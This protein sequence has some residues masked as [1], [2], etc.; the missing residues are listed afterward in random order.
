VRICRYLQI[1]EHL[2]TLHIAQPPPRS[3]NDK[4]FQMGDKNTMMVDG[5]ECEILFTREKESIFKMSAPI[6]HPFWAKLFGFLNL[7]PGNFFILSS[8]IMKNLCF[9]DPKIREILL[10]KLSFSKK[11]HIHQ[12]PFSILK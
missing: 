5:V 2:Y 9:F 1:V 4:L 12:Y 11:C 3:Q 8:T 10:S 6:L 7:V